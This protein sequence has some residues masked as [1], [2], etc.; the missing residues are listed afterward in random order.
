MGEKGSRD[1]CPECSDDRL[2]KRDPEEFAES[3]AE[4]VD[5]LFFNLIL[6]MFTIRI[7][8]LGSTVFPSMVVRY[9]Q[10][11]IGSRLDLFLSIPIK[12]GSLAIYLMGIFTYL[13]HF[14]CILILKL[15]DCLLNLEPKIKNKIGT[16]A[17]KYKYEP[18]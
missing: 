14:L 1:S 12:N 7:R 11:P 18:V 16:E 4:P 6:R 5:P 9:P 3:E 8:E 15:E 2:L 17:H 13:S 10:A